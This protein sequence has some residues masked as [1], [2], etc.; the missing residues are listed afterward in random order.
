MI[1]QQNIQTRGTLFKKPQTETEPV[2]DFVILAMIFLF[3]LVVLFFSKSCG[4]ESRSTYSLMIGTTSRRF[5]I[6]DPISFQPSGAVSSVLKHF[7]WLVFSKDFSRVFLCFLQVRRPTQALLKQGN[8]LFYKC[9]HQNQQRH[10]FR[11][12]NYYLASFA[13]PLRLGFLR[14][15]F[16]Y[17]FQVRLL[18]CSNQTLNTNQKQ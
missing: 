8:A 17:F 4:L 11:H 18:P 1:K 15:F 2:W 14:G 10:A 13:S 3:A 12:K 5:P 9:M 7:A 16:D 6:V